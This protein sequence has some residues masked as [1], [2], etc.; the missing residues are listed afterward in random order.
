MN[1]LAAISRH[2]AA[3][4]TR[5]TGRRCTVRLRDRGFMKLVDWEK[6]V[7]HWYSWEPEKP[8]DSPANAESFA[9]AV[10]LVRSGQDLLT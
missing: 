9:Q 5:Q 3:E 1:D 7:M 10:A 6:G 8:S 4:A 2:L